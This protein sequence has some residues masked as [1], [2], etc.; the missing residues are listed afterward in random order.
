MRDRMMKAAG[1]VLCATIAVMP[2]SALAFDVSKAS[3][4]FDLVSL[5]NTELSACSIKTVDMGNRAD[6]WPY[7]CRLSAWP[8][9]LSKTVPVGEY[10][11]RLYELSGWLRRQAWKASLIIGSLRP[12]RARM[13][14]H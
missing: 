3:S 6:L 2:V 4:N 14:L 9:A 10:P 11:V 12:C 8:T 7:R 13:S 5:D 1:A